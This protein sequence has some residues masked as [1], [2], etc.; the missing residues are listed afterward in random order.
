M[1]MMANAER[2][3][4]TPGAPGATRAGGGGKDPPVEPL[5]GVLPSKC[6]PTSWSLPSA[7]TAVRESVSVV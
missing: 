6:C 1:K 7:F 3:S 5:E 2:G 4:H